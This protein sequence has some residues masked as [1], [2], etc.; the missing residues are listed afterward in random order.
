MDVR[1]FRI[2]N[3][4]NLFLGISDDGTQYRQV[5]ISGINTNV[6]RAPR[7][8]INNDNYWHP[9]ENFEPIPLTEEWLLK[10]GFENWGYGSLYSNEHEK[11]TRYVLHNILDGTSNFEIHFIESNYGNILNNEYVISCDEDDRINW[12]VELKN[13]HQL[14]NLYFALTN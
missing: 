7:I 9:V 8:K 10:F 12:G 13:V 14:Q 1:E 4:Y 2:G 11:Y 6:L 3:K 5:E